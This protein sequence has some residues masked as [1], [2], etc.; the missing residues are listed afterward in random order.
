[1]NL[2]DIFNRREKGRKLYETFLEETK[3]ILESHQ[4]TINDLCSFC[5][6]A[7]KFLRSGHPMEP[8]YYTNCGE[9]NGTGIER[10]YKTLDLDNSEVLFALLKEPNGRE[11]FLNGCIT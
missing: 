7:K 1:M 6:G 4:K 5:K 2:E 11:W 3:K 8:A 10:T 9:C